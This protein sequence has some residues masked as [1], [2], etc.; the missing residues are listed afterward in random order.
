MKLEDLPDNLQQDLEP[1]ITF[2]DGNQSPISDS[3]EYDLL[4]IE[5]VTYLT[6]YN[7][8]NV[9]WMSDWSGVLFCGVYEGLMDILKD[10][11]VEDI[12]LLLNMREHFASFGALFHL[13]TGDW[14]KKNN[15]RTH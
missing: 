13:V 7:P 6:D 1:P 5:Y 3:N 8:L 4:R 9:S 14:C 15:S 12:Q 10:K 11:T 2:D